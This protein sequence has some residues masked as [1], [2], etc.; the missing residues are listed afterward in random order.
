VAP[1][2]RVLVETIRKSNFATRSQVDEVLAELARHSE[3]LDALRSLERLL[4]D[5]IRR[6][7]LATHGQ[8]E[9]VLAALHRIDTVEL[10]EAIRAAKVTH[11]FEALFEAIQG[12]GKLPVKQML[13]S[14]NGIHA[15]IHGLCERLVFQRTVKTIPQ[16]VLQTN[17]SLPQPVM[18]SSRTASPARSTGTVPTI[19]GYLPTTI[20][21]PRV[22]SSAPLSGSL[23][24]SNR[25]APIEQVACGLG[26]NAGGSIRSQSLISKTPW[27]V[28]QKIEPSGINY[29][30][31]GLQYP[32]FS[33]TQQE[34]FGINHR[35]DIVDE[36]K[37]NSSIKSIS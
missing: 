11:E 14:I 12:I 3:A 34:Q 1:L 7:N 29:D 6:A 24:G 35:G 21:S 4:A 23:G 26:S 37:F 9:E 5:V 10:L 30:E 15:E 22:M 27:W 28:N 16:Q 33:I 8:M 20:S 19:P 36:A 32:V 17:V 2:D 25:S 31:S 18:M 13:A